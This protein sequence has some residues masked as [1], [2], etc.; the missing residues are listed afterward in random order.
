MIRQFLQKEKIKIQKKIQL[1]LGQEN[2]IR[3]LNQK[4]I[5]RHQSQGILIRRKR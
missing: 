5:M 3:K 2:L 1:P 4:K